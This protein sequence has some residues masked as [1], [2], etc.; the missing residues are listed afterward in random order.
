[1]MMTHTYNDFEGMHDVTSTQPASTD[2][3][4]TTGDYLYFARDAKLSARL[5]QA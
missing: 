5:S 1:M 2:V 3:G 4:K